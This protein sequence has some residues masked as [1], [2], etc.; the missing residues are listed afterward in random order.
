MA[1]ENNKNIKY[2]NKNKVVSLGKKLK[3][4]TKINDVKNI[5][6]LFVNAVKNKHL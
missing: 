2:E 4:E 1:T 3:T 5:I 6:T